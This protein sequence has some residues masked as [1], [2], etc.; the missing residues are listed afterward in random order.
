M[1]TSGMWL[2]GVSFFWIAVLTMWLAG[3]PTGYGDKQHS[4]QLLGSPCFGD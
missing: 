3:L 1:A 4:G 2:A